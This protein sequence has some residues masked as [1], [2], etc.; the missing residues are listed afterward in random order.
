[1]C[2]NYL[3]SAHPTLLSLSMNAAPSRKTKHCIK[4]APYVNFLQ[5]NAGFRSA[6]LKV[7]LIDTI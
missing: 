2:Y 4:I 1:M 5:P 6:P 3:L 7:G